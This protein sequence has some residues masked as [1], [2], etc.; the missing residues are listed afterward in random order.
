MASTS[1]AM[2]TSNILSSLKSSVILFPGQGSQYVGMA[3]QLCPKA[4]SLFEI[5]NRVLGYDLLS[6]CRNGPEDELNRTVHSQPAV[7]VS[8]LAAVENLAAKC[9]GAISKCVATAGFSIGEFAALVFAQSLDF[10]DALKLIK[11]RA[12]ATQVISDSIPSGM[13]TL[14]YGSDGKKIGQ[15]CALAKEFCIR[16]GMN[17]DEAVCSVSNHLFAHASVIGGHEKALEFVEAHKQDFGIRRMK[18][19]AVSG[20]FHTDLMKPASLELKKHLSSMKIEDP[21]IKVYTNVDANVY[22]GKEQIR[23]YLSQHV[24]K[25]VK[26]EQIMHKMYTPKRDEQEDLPVTFECGPQNNLTTMLGMINLNA[27]KIAYN[28]E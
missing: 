21:K 11:I 28:I 6:L 9:P 5:A 2:A 3:K 23:R 1:A 18:R 15:I 8:S 12:E 17:E 10:V 7:F 13:L 19:L 25:P 14:I 24:Y 20:A 26:W 27:K 22:E 4:E 16:S